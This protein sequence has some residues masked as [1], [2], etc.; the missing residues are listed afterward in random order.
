MES[1]FIRIWRW[2]KRTS[3]VVRSRIFSKEGLI[4]WI[5]VFTV[6]QIY[7]GISVRHVGQENKHRIIEIQQSRVHSCSTTYESFRQVFKPFFPPPG[8]RTAKQKRDLAKLDRIINKHKSKCVKQV[9]P[10]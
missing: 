5:I 3:R 8:H 7:N 4:T 2:A 6:Y 10:K 1:K 9:Q